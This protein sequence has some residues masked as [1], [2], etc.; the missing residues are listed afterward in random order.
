M[1][2]TLNC[3]VSQVVMSVHAS[4]RIADEATNDHTIDEPYTGSLDGKHGG[5]L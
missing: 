5:C 4:Y 1:I 2:I 3:V